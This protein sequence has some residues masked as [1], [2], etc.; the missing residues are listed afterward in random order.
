MGFVLPLHSVPFALNVFF[1]WQAV[2]LP[3]HVPVKVVHPVLDV[4]VVDNLHDVPAGE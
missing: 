2:D 3:L 4:V 1:V